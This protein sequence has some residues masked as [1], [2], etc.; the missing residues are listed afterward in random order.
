MSEVRI[1]LDPRNPAQFLACCGLCEVLGGKLPAVPTHFLHDPRT[2][3]QARFAVSG[4]GMGDVLAA[5]TAFKKAQVEPLP[6]FSGGEAP[7]RMVLADGGQIELDW[8]AGR[9]HLSR[10]GNARGG[11]PARVPAAA[12]RAA[13][14]CLLALA[15]A[16]SPRGR[17]CGLRGGR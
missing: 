8:C 6:G 9:L 2:P 1:A 4:V 11:W 16:A 15:R 14:V 5:L 12:T 7:V 10:D 17:S 13:R 3:R